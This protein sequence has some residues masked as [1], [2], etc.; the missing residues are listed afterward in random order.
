MIE[1]IKILLHNHPVLLCVLVPAG[2]AVI[3]FILSQIVGARNIDRQTG[4]SMSDDDFTREAG[5]FLLP[6]GLG[7]FGLAW[8]KHKISSSNPLTDDGLELEDTDPIYGGHK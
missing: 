1:E 6:I 8:L 4:N 5:C 2:W 3:A 7:F